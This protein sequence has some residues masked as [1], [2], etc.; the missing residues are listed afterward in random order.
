MNVLKKISGKSLALEGALK[1]VLIYVMISFIWVFFSDYLV[2]LLIKDSRIATNISILKGWAFIAVTS[3]LLYVLIRRFAV[4]KRKIEKELSV[5]E[6]RWEYALNS[7][8]DGV[9]DW[10]LKRK[11]IY[12]SPQWKE[13]IGYS[14]EEFE[15]SVDTLL[16]N[17]YE[18]DKERVITEIKKHLNG[19]TEQY[20]CEYRLKTKSGNYKWILT[21]GKITEYSPEGVPLRI[22]GTH[23]DISTRRA[24]EDSIRQSEEKYRLISE[25]TDDVIWVYDIA[26]GKYTFVS[27]S[28]YKLKGFTAEE[29]MRHGLKES[30]TEESYNEINKTLPGRLQ[31]YM[32]G[33]ES[34]KSKLYEVSQTCKDGSIIN[35]EVVTTLIKGEDGF[36]KE[37]LGVTR[38]V[39]I[40]KQAEKKLIE[41]EEKYRSIYENSSV[42]II[43]ANPNG[44]IVSANQEAVKLFG[45]KEEELRNA[46]YHGIMDDGDMHLEELLSNINL[47]GNAHGEIT[48][49]KKDG[50]KF[51]GD[52]SSNMFTDIHGDLFN[53][54]IVRDLTEQ[55][56]AVDLLRKS[57]ELYRNIFEYSPVAA[58]F[59]DREARIIFWNKTAEKVF[60]WNKDEVIGK[61]FTQFFIPKEDRESV[62]SNVHYLINNIPRETTLNKN[63]RKDGSS[64]LCEWNNTIIHDENGNAI[65]VISLAK[66][67]TEEKRLESEIRKSQKELHELNEK[68]EQRVIERTN[69]LEIANKELEAFSYSVSHD[70]RAPLRAIDGFSQMAV[71][72]Y[73]DVLDDNGKRILGI[74]QSSVKKMGH[75]ID[76]LLSL[77]RLGRK[78]VSIS[79]VNLKP[80]FESIYIE[81]IAQYDNLK[82][83]F[84]ISDL[85][86]AN[87]DYNLIKHVI[88]N[89]I[90]NAIKFSSKA[91][92]PKIEISGY[93]EGDETVF[94]V[95]DNGLRF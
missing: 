77:S 65:T 29:V 14:D 45:M 72:D 88:Y 21:R 25:N 95:K 61:K 82:I 86:K 13:M 36:V 92:N 17:L 18:N 91:E 11:T 93:E 89:L 60:G 4:T 54:L 3:M 22:I 42:A 63:N 1:I 35:T 66:D 67:V 62:E 78:A 84:V 56:K 30:L 48:F 37:I 5:S 31:R 16:R 41:S 58:V 7:A 27:P 68:L 8:K 26:I 40:R 87:V 9:W 32:R 49:I 38:D 57:E 28:V 6:K 51:W 47:N 19:E 15:N 34:E 2:A 33:D 80:L 69:Q 55:K 24:L 10:D 12:F 79:E 59:W 43:I 73:K 64:I 85:P 23:T 71:D 81:Q 90:S 20:L 50:S 39:S 76:D 70:L 44:V 52:I 83:D 53:T 75:L 74:I 46:G 94:L